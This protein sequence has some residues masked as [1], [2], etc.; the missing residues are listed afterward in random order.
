[1][2]G[3][4]DCPVQ[5]ATCEFVTSVALSVCTPSGGSLD[6]RCQ[7]STH[8]HTL[9]ASEK[10]TSCNRIALLQFHTETDRDWYHDNE[11]DI[12]LPGFPAGH[13]ADCGADRHRK[14]SNDEGAFQAHRECS[15]KDAPG[16][17]DREARSRLSPMAHG[18]PQPPLPDEPPDE[19]F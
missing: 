14:C 8:S 15:P 6:L 18:Q 10:P 17:A 3:D 7:S 12:A 9:R 5:S 11:P 13:L 4:V 19:V 1:M 16:P 2:H